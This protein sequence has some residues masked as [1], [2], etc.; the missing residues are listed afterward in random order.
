MKNFFNQNRKWIGFFLIFIAVILM[1]TYFF[2]SKKKDENIIP[3]TKN[4]TVISNS[5]DSEDDNYTEDISTWDGESVGLDFVPTELGNC[6]LNQDALRFIDNSVSNLSED[7]Q[8]WL[9]S[10]Y[11][12]ENV[13]KV[14]WNKL[15]TIDYDAENIILQLHV[16]ADQKCN[17]KCMYSQKEKTWS[18][19]KL[20]D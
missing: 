16:I 9:Y 3:D 13:E 10:D 4:T 1:C 19:Y 12:I 14:T 8:W 6:D 2:L 11:G 20:R 18:F 15:I 17:I 5:E 7:L